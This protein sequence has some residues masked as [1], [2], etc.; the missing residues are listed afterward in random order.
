MKKTIQIHL[1]CL[2]ILFFLNIN[3]TAS[4]SP[5]LTPMAFSMLPK[6]ENVRISPD[7]EHVLFIA[8]TDDRTLI[9]CKHLDTGKLT[10]ITSTDNRKFKFRE[11]QWANNDTILFSACFPYYR[12]MRIPTVETRMFTVKSDG[13]EEY[14]ILIK[15]KNKSMDKGEHISQFQDNVISLLPDDPDHILMG[16]DFEKAAQPSVYKIN[17]ETGAREWV[18]RFRPNVR[19]WMADQQ[20]RIRLGEVFDAI[21]T[22]TGILLYSLE[23]NKWKEVW[24]TD[25]FSAPPA[26]P[27]GFGLDPNILYVRSYHNGRNCIFKVDV[28]QSDLPMELIASDDRYDIDG[29]LIYS[30]KTRDVVGV[31]HSE[32]DGGRIYWDEGY[33]MFQKAIDK[34]LQDTTNYLIDF[35]R[36][37]RRYIVY[38]TSD[39]SPGTYYVGD[40]DRGSL[41]PIHE[42]YPQLKGRLRGKKK[43]LYTARDGKKIEAYL[44]LP[45]GYNPEKPGP[46]IIYPHGGPMARDYGGF[47]YWAEYLASKGY[48]VLQPNFRG[49]S[50]YGWEFEQEAMQNFGLSMQDDL[51]DAANW[52]ITQHLADPDRLAITGASY[53]GYAALMG[54]VKTPD[55]F[56]CAVSFAGVSDLK[57]LVESH[58][59]YLSFKVV[60]DQFGTDGRQLKDTSPLQN[61][62][63]IKIPIL[64]AHGEMDRVVS[65]EQSRKMANKLERKNKVYTYIELEDGD[66]N[67]SVQE[68]R[69][70][71]F[72]AMDEF[73]DKYLK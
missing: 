70:S 10:G 30:P 7:G 51:T 23:N 40:R 14:K 58:R 73:L 66:H 12:G 39:T 35:S 4:D 69:H 27:L 62:D 33:Q 24:K 37:E 47:D 29:E 49:S 22:Q 2:L 45:A 31:Y 25:I 9:I 46:G 63:E 16:I 65:V 54:A 48:T 19:D 17:I 32:V 1:F 64:L 71:F 6:I 52:L 50:G 8:N 53:G 44:T 43:V 59:N 28:S 72:S 42:T 26:T 36:N 21:T 13:S 20:G 5:P 18:Q 3:C 34:V 67:L 11:V 68:N 60:R 57:T 41:T 56:K 15:P 55:L 38:A 61:V